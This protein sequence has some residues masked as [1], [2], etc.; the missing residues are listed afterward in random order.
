MRLLGDLG[1]CLLQPML[2][3]DGHGAFTGVHFETNTDFAK[4]I[5]PG[6]SARI[7][8]FEPCSEVER[9]PAFVASSPFS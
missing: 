8:V 2:A 6:R 5:V 4:A 3:V 1:R 9:G 7:G